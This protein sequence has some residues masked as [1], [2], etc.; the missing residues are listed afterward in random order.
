MTMHWFALVMFAAVGC[1]GASPVLNIGGGGTGGLGGAGGA[2][3]GSGLGGGGASSGGSGGAS[4]GSTGGA[5]GGGDG[6]GGTGGTAGGGGTGGTEPGPCELAEVECGFLEG[7]YCGT[8]EGQDECG[9]GGPGTCGQFCECFEGEICEG[10]G[11]H[12]TFCS[13]HE[14]ETPPSFCEYQYPINDYKYYCC[15]TPNGWQW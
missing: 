5:A 12:T 10:N 3:A 6:G 8:C 4:G 9:A 15:D 7:T 2:T 11:Q 13:C 1:Y 14:T